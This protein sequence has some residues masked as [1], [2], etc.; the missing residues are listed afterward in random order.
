M[1]RMLQPEDNIDGT[2][3]AALTP[4]EFIE[5]VD[6]IDEDDAQNPAGS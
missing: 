4:A 5:A 6:A 1:G 2:S 3:D